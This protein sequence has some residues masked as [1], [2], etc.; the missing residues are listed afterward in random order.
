VKQFFA[1]IALFAAGLAYADR[2]PPGTND[3]ISARLK[4]A[5]ELCK[6]GQSCGQATAA[7]AGGAAR[8]G[9]AVYNQFCFACHSTGV[10][11]APKL[12]NVAD[13]TPRLAKGNDVVWKSVTA[14]LNAMPV[15]GT[16]MN[17]SDDELKSAITYM[18]K[19]Q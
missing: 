5:G 1:V 2:V 4:P 8:S 3:E 19:A 9:E 6:A 16:C 12:H 15:K 13:W 17:C 18:S 7:A 11:G 14:G 10:G